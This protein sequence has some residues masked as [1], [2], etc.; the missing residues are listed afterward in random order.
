MELHRGEGAGAEDG[1]AHWR[2]SVFWRHGPESRNE[3]MTPGGGRA[4]SA[5]TV[6]SMA[7]L[8]YSV[9]VS[10]ASPYTLHDPAAKAS[11]KI[12]VSAPSILGGVR[13][14][15]FEGA[16]RILG[17]RVTF[18]LPDNQRPWGG[19]FPSHAEPDLTCG[20]GQMNEP[21]YVVDPQGRIV[22]TIS[23]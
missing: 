5:F 3:L 13:T 16:E 14:W 21:I 9:D 20:A 11:A 6:Q 12:S 22:R 17:R 19:G 4:L 8:G 7:D 18:D 1:W 15:Q 23:R 10:Q 2:S